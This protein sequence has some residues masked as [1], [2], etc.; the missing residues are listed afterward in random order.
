MP[1]LAFYI[2]QTLP[3]QP[4]YPNSRRNRCQE[5]PNSFPMENWRKPPGRPRTTW[6]KTIQQ[7]LKS[8]N[9]SLNWCGSE[10]STL[11]T[12]VYILALC[13]PSGACHKRHLHNHLLVLLR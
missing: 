5:D 2:T 8:S 3:L 7:D 11:E 4:H 10:S 9:L 12:D 6:M 13:I 1:T